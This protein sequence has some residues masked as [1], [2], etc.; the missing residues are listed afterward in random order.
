MSW[1]TALISLEER[2]GDGCRHGKLFP[3]TRD[4]WFIC[5]PVRHRGLP[6]ELPQRAPISRS[7]ALNL[8][9]T[10]GKVQFYAR[11][12]VLCLPLCHTPIGAGRQVEESAN[13]QPGA[14]WVSTGRAGAEAGR[15]DVGLRTD[16]AFPCRV[17]T[18]C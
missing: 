2:R 4:F 13:L 8:Y 7:T 14:I 9:T 18:K 11:T 17:E 5:T 10:A 15:D 6:G 1:R 12:T 3:V 16:L